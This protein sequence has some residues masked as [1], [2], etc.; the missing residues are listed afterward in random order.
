MNNA[1][2]L[3]LYDTMSEHKEIRRLLI[4]AISIKEYRMCEDE[5][6]QGNKSTLTRMRINVLCTCEV[7]LCRPDNGFNHLFREGPFMSVSGRDQVS[8][9]SNNK[10]LETFADYVVL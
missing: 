3:G 8:A 10:L 2:D 6:Y 4:L 1:P 7:D 5:E 9:F